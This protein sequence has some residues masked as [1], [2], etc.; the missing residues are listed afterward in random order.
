MKILVTRPEIDQQQTIAS[1]DRL[2]M[3]AIASPVIEIVPLSFSLPC[4]EWQ[5][6]IVTSRNALRMLSSQ[7]IGALKHIPLYCVGE[8]TAELARN[9]G[10]EV[11]ASVAPDVASLE[12]DLLSSLNAGSGSLLYL[13]G[14]VRSGR[15][16]ETLQERGYTACLQQVYESRARKALSTEAVD[17]IKKNELDGIL[18]YSQR[19][20]RLFLGLI[21]KSGLCD[22]LHDVIFYCLSP[23]VALPLEG[24]GYP[25]VVAHAPNEKSLLACVQRA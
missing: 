5:A 3:E 8:K 6:V 15:L 18:L 23:A 9:L 21:E 10:F 19:S 12:N 25:L 22:H 2:G 7:T 14:A 1:L 20:C 13:A 4:E 24:L 11:V 16:F 17:A